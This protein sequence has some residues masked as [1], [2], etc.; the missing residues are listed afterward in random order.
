[1]RSDERHQLV[2]AMVLALALSCLLLALPSAPSRAALPGPSESYLGQYKVLSDLDSAAT[3]N[4]S[5]GFWLLNRTG[6]WDPLT[7]G[8]TFFPHLGSLNGSHAAVSG[9]GCASFGGTVS[10]SSSVADISYAFCSL[11]DPMCMQS[12]SVWYRMQ[13]LWSEAGGSVHPGGPVYTSL[14]AFAYDSSGH[15]LRTLS[16]AFPAIRSWEEYAT[17]GDWRQATFDIYT[18][19]AARVV[20]GAEMIVDD[21]SLYPGV[22]GVSCQAELDLLSAE[23]PASSVHFSYFNS[24]SGLGLQSALLVPSV[25]WHGGTY[26]VGAFGGLESTIGVAVGETIGYNITDYFGRTLATGSLIVNSTTVFVDVPVPLVTVY[27]GRP[28]WYNSSLP[29]EWDIE[30]LPTGV[31][32]HASGWSLE[33]IAGWYTFRWGEEGGAQAGD[34]DLYIDGNAS[35][36]SSLSMQDFSLVMEPTWSASGR[37]GGVLPDGWSVNTTALWDAINEVA[38]TP[39]VRAILFVI[40]VAGA[41][42]TVYGLAR[43]ARKRMEGRTQEDE[44]R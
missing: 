15:V 18:A 13:C 12:V 8:L 27:I 37:D 1:M 26:R 28:D 4:T 36:G 6:P 24:Y 22:A 10:G 30:C 43:R 3:Q 38:A 14:F 23:S 21:L 32:A 42:V 2:R 41:A 11:Q 9:A 16:Q 29:P 5:W 40:M 7:T 25:T 33:L 19:G 17:A 44:Y 35:Q 31:S 34:V 20:V 39:E